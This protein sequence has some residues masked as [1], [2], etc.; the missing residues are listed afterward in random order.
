[1]AWLRE[2]CHPQPPSNNCCKLQD[3]GHIS[4]MLDLICCLALLN[5]TGLKYVGAEASSCAK[6][7]VQEQVEGVQM[8]GVGSVIVWY[9]H[10]N[11]TRNVLV[12]G[13][14][15]GAAADSIM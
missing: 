10:M 5:S 7:C 11:P 9:V 15:E 6:L 4:E 12:D 8:C 2:K 1:V 14:T 3:T 13:Y